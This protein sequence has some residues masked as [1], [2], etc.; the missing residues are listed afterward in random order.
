ML[1]EQIEHLMRQQN[2]IKISNAESRKIKK[3]F[4][5]LKKQD[6]K[7]TKNGIVKVVEESGGKISEEE[8]NRIACRVLE[9]VRNAQKILQAWEEIKQIGAGSPEEILDDI[10]SFINK[11]RAK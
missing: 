6:E 1:Y 2:P 5:L 4:D 8:V 10:F 11:L 9:D 3:F 7:R